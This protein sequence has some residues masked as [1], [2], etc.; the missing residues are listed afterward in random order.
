MTRRRAQRERWQRRDD[1]I[2]E[3]RL[4][5]AGQLIL[6]CLFFTIWV[7]DT[8][9]LNYTTWLN[10]HIPL[11]VRLP[12]GLVLLVVSGYLA[13][14]GLSIVFGEVREQP[15]VIRKSVFGLV[16]HPIYLSEILLYL[17]FLVISLSLAAVV[18]WGLAI[19]FLHYISRHEERLLLARFGQDY[20]LYMQEVPMWI[21][22]LRKV[23]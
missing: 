10:D 21:P 16:R 11:A 18:V 20:A 9:F 23:R 22:R 15:G 3:H 19:L 12:L 2:G 5:D 17:G 4:G 13:A 14:R 1:L 8:F 6:A 7:A